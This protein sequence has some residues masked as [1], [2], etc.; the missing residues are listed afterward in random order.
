MRY[1]DIGSKNERPPENF[2]AQIAFTQLNTFL[3]TTD[4]RVFSW[5]GVTTCLGREVSQGTVDNFGHDY[6]EELVDEVEFPK[7]LHEQ[8][9]SIIQI[10]TGRAHILALDT[11]GKVYSWGR[12]DYG[13]L[14]LGSRGKSDKGKDKPTLIGKLKKEI[15]QIFAGETQSFAITKEGEV[16]AWG[17]N[18]HK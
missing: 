13:Q 9:P 7:D 16:Y 2:V 14:G 10:A 8:D 1:K 11:S 12:N 18:K 15:C 4:G 6:L 5:G 3:L 17:N